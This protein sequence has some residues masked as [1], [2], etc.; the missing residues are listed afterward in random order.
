MSNGFAEDPHA[1][2]MLIDYEFS[3][4][5]VNDYREL[6]GD[7]G[8]AKVFRPIRQHAVACL[9]RLPSIRVF[10]SSCKFIQNSVTAALT[11]EVGSGPLRAA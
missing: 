2:T 7:R 5:N 11:A 8:K 4:K 9:V 10:V 1:S 3:M 6:G